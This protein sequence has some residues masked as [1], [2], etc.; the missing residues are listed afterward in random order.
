M[1]TTR[2]CLWEVSDPYWIYVFDG[3]CSSGTQ[4]GNLACCVLYNGMLVA[5]VTDFW[6]GL[7]WFFRLGNKKLLQNLISLS[8][9]NNH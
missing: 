1:F 4:K 2:G 6:N 5:R 9:C 8:A 7:G 3:T